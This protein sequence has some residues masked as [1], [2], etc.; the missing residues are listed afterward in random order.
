MPTG[1]KIRGPLLLVVL[2]VA[3]AILGTL[4]G[5]AAP[6]ADLPGIGE[7][8]RTSALFTAY[9]M[10]FCSAVTRSTLTAGPSSISYLVTVGPRLNP[11]TARPVARL[12][13]PYL[14]CDLLPHGPC[15]ESR[16]AV[17]ILRRWS[18]C[19]ALRPLRDHHLR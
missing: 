3:A 7:T 14:A 13:A 4:G 12:F 2:G 5:S 16:A 15:G 8:I 19:R 17:E 18:R 10:F 9:A 1:P 11:L 6:I